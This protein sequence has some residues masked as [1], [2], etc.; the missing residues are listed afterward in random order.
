[1]NRYNRGMD[2]W[3]ILAPFPMCGEC[4]VVKNVRFKSV[5]QP[6]DSGGALGQSQHCDRAES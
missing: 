3:I 2:R 6:I 5:L 1:M 4:D